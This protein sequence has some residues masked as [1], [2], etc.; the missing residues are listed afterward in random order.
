[1]NGHSLLFPV[2]GWDNVIKQKDT[3]LSVVALPVIA[4]VMPVVFF[5]QERAKTFIPSL[6]LSICDKAATFA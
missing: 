3:R 6:T 5:K 4:Y 1:L 2:I